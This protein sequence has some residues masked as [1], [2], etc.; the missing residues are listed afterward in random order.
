MVIIR[1]RDLIGLKSF[2]FLNR[3]SVRILYKVIE[4]VIV[5]IRDLI[6]LQ[7]FSGFNRF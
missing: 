4:V 3:F 7:G 5:R 2:P 6:H 1:I